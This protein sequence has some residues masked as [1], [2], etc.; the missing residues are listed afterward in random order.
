M[1]E[2]CTSAHG[3][4]QEPPTG[5][6]AEK[7]NYQMIGIVAAYAYRQHTSGVKQLKSPVGKQEPNGVVYIYIGLQQNRGQSRAYLE[8]SLLVQR[9]SSRH[10]RGGRMESEKM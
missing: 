7:W 1:G 3:Q 2:D 6:R 8:Q 4:R 9:H 5:D 10:A